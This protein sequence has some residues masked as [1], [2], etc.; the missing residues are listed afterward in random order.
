MKMIPLLPML[1]RL[2]LALAIILTASACSTRKLPKYERPIAKTQHQRVRTTAYTHSE[3]DHLKYG[4][5]T[6]I[7][8]TL[9]SG[10]AAA[11]WARWPLGTVFRISETGQTYRVDDIGWALAGR[12]T[13]DL[14]KP[15]RS[16]MNSWGVRNVGI[17]I[18]EWGSLENSLRV[19][20][21]RARFPHVK[22][23]IDQI[24]DQI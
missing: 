9:Q 21:P 12:N 17:E 10:S 19:L 20:K 16:A 6:A 3:A 5:K 2:I 13:I 18:I 22:R 4:R 24:E 11:D 23:M 1:N 15:S 7:G 14:Y 8:T